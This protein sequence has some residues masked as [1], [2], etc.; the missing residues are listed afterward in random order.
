MERESKIILEQMIDRKAKEFSLLKMKTH[1]NFV[2]PI[3]REYWHFFTKITNQFL[4]EAL[5][6][7]LQ[8]SISISGNSV[9]ILWFPDPVII[10]ED[11]MNEFLRF[12]NEANIE[13]EMGGRFWCDEERYDFVYEVILKENFF[14]NCM[15][16][17]AKQM[18]D[19]PY[20]HFRD[21]QIPLMMMMINKWKSD[22]AI[23]YIRELREKG[24]VNNE[25]YGSW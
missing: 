17:A 22:L 4:F 18:F 1:N 10:N 16:D 11:N 3:C 24:Y 8:A 23:Q 14:R 20:A 19:I 6:M 2:V 7:D 21:L 9:R 12:S 25:D 5:T 13:L 15:D